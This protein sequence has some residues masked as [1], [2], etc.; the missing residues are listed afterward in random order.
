MDEKTKAA[1]DG[2]TYTDMLRRWRFALTGDPLFQGPSGDYYAERMK[3]IRAEI[4]PE[5]HTRVSKEIGWNF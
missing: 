1:I 2:M 4:G 5:E 3:K